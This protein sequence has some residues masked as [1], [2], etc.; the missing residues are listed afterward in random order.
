[1]RGSPPPRERSS[2]FGPQHFAKVQ[3]YQ[4]LV[5]QENSKSDTDGGHSPLYVLPTNQRREKLMSE[6]ENVQIVRQLY[7][8]FKQGDIQALWKTLA[9]KI[10]WYEPGPLDIL[11]WAGVFRISKDRR[12]PR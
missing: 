3:P 7:E 6:Q 9:E 1:M 11:P 10:E 4:K 8:A 12:I 5:R 2:F